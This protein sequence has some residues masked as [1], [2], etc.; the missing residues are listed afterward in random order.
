MAA[1][2]EVIDGM[3]SGFLDGIAKLMTGITQI[4]VLQLIKARVRT[5]QYQKELQVRMSSPSHR[6]QNPRPKLE[7]VE[8]ERRKRRERNEMA[9]MTYTSFMCIGGRLWQTVYHDV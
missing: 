3:L 2:P 1:L 7:A 4:S 5:H 8:G 6:S 9:A